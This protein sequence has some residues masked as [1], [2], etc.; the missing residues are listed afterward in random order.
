MMK[1]LSALFLAHRACLQ[2]GRLLRR[3][4]LTA[5]PSPAALSPAAEGKF[6]PGTYEG[7]GQGLRR[8]RSRWP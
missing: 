1:K 2:P 6:T 8:A 7:E 5:A 4:A 3:H